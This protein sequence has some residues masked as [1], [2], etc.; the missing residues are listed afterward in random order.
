MACM[1]VEKTRRKKEKREGD[2]AVVESTRR[3]NGGGAFVS[4]SFCYL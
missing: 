4:E 3:D 1:V 2:C